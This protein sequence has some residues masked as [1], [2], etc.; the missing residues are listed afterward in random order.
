[1][2]EREPV[3]RIG[4]RPVMGRKEVGLRKM[5]CFV[6]CSGWRQRFLACLGSVIKGR[7]GAWAGG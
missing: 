4:R 7:F 3:E 2:V 6:L 1:M 5:P